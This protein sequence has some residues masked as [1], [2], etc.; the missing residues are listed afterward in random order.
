MTKQPEALRLATELTT[1]VRQSFEDEQVILVARWFVEDAAAE[2]RRLHDETQYM[3][4]AGIQQAGEV[5]MLEKQNA[6]LLA[7]LKDL[8]AG[9]ERLKDQGY[10][11]SDCQKQARAAIAKATGEQA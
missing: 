6:E 5:I 2:L 7:A 11:V 3:N 8:E 1:A 9:Y 4:Q 10:P